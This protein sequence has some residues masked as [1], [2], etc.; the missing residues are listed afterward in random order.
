MPALIDYT[1]DSVY[2]EMLDVAPENRRVLLYLESIDKL[3]N[4][5]VEYAAA[6]YTENFNII[7]HN[8][9]VIAS[10]PYSTLIDKIWQQ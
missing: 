2:E 6:Y 1:Y 5:N 8:R 9:E 4:L 10:T 7:E 3:C